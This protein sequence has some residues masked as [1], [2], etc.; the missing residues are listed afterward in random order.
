M[1]FLVN[2]V[3][4]SQNICVFLY[5][6]TSFLQELHTDAPSQNVPVMENVNFQTDQQ[7]MQEVPHGTAH[8]LGEYVRPSTFIG[9]RSCDQGQSNMRTPVLQLSRQNQSVDHGTPRRADVPVWMR[10][11]PG[12]SSILDSSFPCEL[13]VPSKAERRDISQ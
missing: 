9:G 6:S 3:Y 11:S 12:D 4:S 13:D 2:T 1:E 8:H 7:N 10:D 5:M